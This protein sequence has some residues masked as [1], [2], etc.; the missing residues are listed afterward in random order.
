MKELSKDR[1]VATARGLETFINDALG[2]RPFGKSLSGFDFLPDLL[3]AAFGRTYVETI[4][5]HADRLH[6]AIRKTPMQQVIQAYLNRTK[7]IGKRFDLA[8]KEVILA[9]DHTDEEYYGKLSSPYL[10]AWTGEAAVTGKWKFLTCAIVNRDDPPKVPVLSIPTPI[11]YDV[12]RQAQ[13]I[14]DRIRPLFGDIKLTLWDRGFYK[15]D[16]LKTLSDMDE[17]YLMLVPK[18]DKVKAELAQMEDEHRKAVHYE[19][20]YYKDKHKHQGT[21]TLALLKHIFDPRSKKRWDWSFATNVPDLDMENII[22]TYKGRWRI[23]TGFR[24]QDQAHVDSKST[25]VQIR[26]F[27]FAFEQALQFAWGALYKDQ[28]PYK[29]FVHQ[30]WHVSSERVQREKSRGR[31]RVGARPSASEDEGR[32]GSRDT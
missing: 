5:N 17:R 23:E 7:A 9:F 32:G 11:G 19:F 25:E 12:S 1:L 29:A 21:T 24:V 26:Y 2:L 10:H 20:E 8:S 4:G 30:L 14:I 27:Y 22:G 15:H 6:Q 16:L 31:P 18:T 13:F 28:A 3:L